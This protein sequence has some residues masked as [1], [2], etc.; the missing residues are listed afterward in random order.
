M[1]VEREDIL[2]MMN[3]MGTKLPHH[4]T[5]ILPDENIHIHVVSHFSTQNMTL[6]H[7]AY[8]VMII[9]NKY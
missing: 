7:I 6:I 1:K 8:V 2:K 5:W 3:G 4:N 9:T